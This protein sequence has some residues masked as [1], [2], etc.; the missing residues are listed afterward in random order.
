MILPS[1]VDF[2]S[3]LPVEYLSS[4]CLRVLSLPVAALE[5]APIVPLAGTHGL[6]A[7]AV[8]APAVGVVLAAT[9]SDAPVFA[10]AVK[11]VAHQLGQH[12]LLIRTGR[13]PEVLDLV[14]IEA[15]LIGSADVIS[16]RDLIFFRHSNSSLWLVSER[17]G[18]TISLSDCGLRIEQSP[19][20]ADQEER[21][22]GLCRAAAEIVRLSRPSGRA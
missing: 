3:S 19:P 17:S 1:K 5:G 9:P 21:A 8:H 15:A 6:P 11:E 4:P 20:F 18:P 2:M 13:F 10:N 14:T 22:A 7:G 16:L 12:V